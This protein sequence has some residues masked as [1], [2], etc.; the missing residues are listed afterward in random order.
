MITVLGASGFIGSHLTKRLD[1]LGDQYMA[2]DREAGVPR[3]LSGHVIYCVGVTADFRS[4]PFDTVEAHVCRLMEALRYSQF[5]S[6]LY[7]SSARLY[8]DADSTSEDAAIRIAP[9]DANHLYN[10]SKAM[11]ESLALNCGRPTRVVRLSNVYGADLNSDNFLPSLIRDA[12]VHKRIVLQTSADSAKDYIS[13][14]NVVDAL[15]NIATSG[16]ERLYNIA[17]GFNVSNGELAEALSSATA[18]TVEFEQD[19]PSVTFPAINIDRLQ[20]EFNFQPSH[21]LDDIPHL[22]DLYRR[23]LESSH[24]QS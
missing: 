9:L 11:G 16:R 3:G 22:V 8:D 1:V 13:I 6:L 21:V 17:S 10:T 5:D 2:F 19:A 4:R 12:V 14:D 15:I 23:N 7:L 18:C 24:D 20:A